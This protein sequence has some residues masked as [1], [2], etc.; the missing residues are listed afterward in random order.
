M[1]GLP[2]GSTPMGQAHTC[3]QSEGDNCNVD[4]IRYGGT[5]ACNFPNYGK[6]LAGANYAGWAMWEYAPGNCS[7]AE[8]VSTFS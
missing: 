7:F 3:A 1:G 8:I 5:A 4:N 2:A 6:S